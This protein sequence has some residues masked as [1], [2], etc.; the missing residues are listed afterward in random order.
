M[1]P[2][3]KKRAA[4]TEGL[5]TH[6][7]PSAGWTRVTNYKINGRVL[8][9]GTQVSIRGEGG[10]FRFVEAVTTE[11]GK[12]W[13]TFLGGRAGMYAWRSFYPSRVKRVH[14]YLTRAS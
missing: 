11:N 8:H 2:R 1:A 14:R 4:K 10:R 6:V 7:D 13:L 9:P 5:S 12:H 3:A